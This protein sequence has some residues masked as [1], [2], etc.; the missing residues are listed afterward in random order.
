[1]VVNSSYVVFNEGVPARFSA[2][3]AENITEPLQQSGQQS[4]LLP[5]WCPRRDEDMIIHAVTPL[6]EVC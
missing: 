5:F 2:R 6:H 4:Q 3:Q 1:M